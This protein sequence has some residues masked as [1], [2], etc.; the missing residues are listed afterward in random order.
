YLLLTCLFLAGSFSAFSQYGRFIVQFKDKKGTPYTF[1][2]PS[3]Y[4][5]AQAIARRNRYHIA[6][7]STDL[8]V[9]PAY[10]DS[11]LS[12]PNVSL[13]NISK[14]MNQV[15]IRTTDS[16]ALV[17]IRSFSFVKQAAPIAVRIMTNALPDPGRRKLEE[18]VQ[19]IQMG[20]DSAAG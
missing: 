19:P 18:D 17:T 3:A 12:V 5:S 20:V 7:D 1:S 16:A 11:I 6:I 9:A 8:P 13:V 2:N 4:L 15:C 10:I 14:W